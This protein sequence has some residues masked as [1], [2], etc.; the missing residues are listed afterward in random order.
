VTNE[1]PVEGGW[2]LP[3]S[4]FFPNPG[5][6]Y[7]MVG[8]EAY[9]YCAPRSTL[10]AGYS[11]NLGPQETVYFVTPSDMI[12]YS[13]IC[14][15]DQP[16]EVCEYHAYMNA[17]NCQCNI[18]EEFKEDFDSYR[19]G[20]GIPESHPFYDTWD[21][22]PNTNVDIKGFNDNGTPSPTGF[23]TSPC[24]GG[25]TD[26]CI[27]VDGSLGRPVP[28]NQITTEEDEII[29]EKSDAFFDRVC[30]LNFWVRGH[31]R[32]GGNFNSIGITS[33]NAEEQGCVDFYGGST[34]HF[35]D[36]VN[37]GFKDGEGNDLGT[38]TFNVAWDDFWAPAGLTVESPVNGSLLFFVQ[39]TGQ[40]PDPL[41]FGNIGP[42]FDDFDVSCCCPAPDDAF[43]YDVA[44]SD[45]GTTDNYTAVNECRS[46]PSSILGL[47]PNIDGVSHSDGYK[48]VFS[49]GFGGWVVYEFPLGFSTNV[50]IWEE[51]Y[52]VTGDNEDAKVQASVD[53][54][55][56]LTI[57]E[58]IP[59]ESWHPLEECQYG[60]R[61]VTLDL[62]LGACFKYIKIIDN[63][64][65][66]CDASD[67]FDIH[68]IEAGD[69]CCPSD[70]PPYVPETDVPESQ[71]RAEPVSAGAAAVM[72]VIACVGVAALAAIGL[73]HLRSRKNRDVDAKMAGIIA[74]P[75]AGAEDQETDI[76]PE[77]KNWFS[78]NPTF[79]SPVGLDDNEGSI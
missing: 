55:N 61:G 13:T 65:A 21:V 8:P 62:P 26:R 7:S 59:S 37:F 44:D 14:G 41:N 2:Y 22:V 25:Q 9:P 45:Q 76:P 71:G 48:Q 42:F 38:S 72:M 50:T 75:H 43:P 73:I 56:W 64:T 31:A 54:V 20:N 28:I 47:P 39:V 15:P 16:N 18:T 40:S 35:D 32:C 52:S 29:L 23:F 3:F 33:A 36:D 4:F 74:G 78:R 60:I 1:N 70:Y 68:A 11:W 49:L 46:D 58:T 12:H 24:R 19:V 5:A 57:A 67:G 30:T 10:C 69:K 53:G 79:D 66:D 77:R 17:P 6:G 51:T 34:I 63:S 27:D